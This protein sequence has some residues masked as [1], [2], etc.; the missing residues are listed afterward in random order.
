MLT[1]AIVLAVLAL[2]KS[3]LDYLCTPAG[4]VTATNIQARIAVVQGRID[5][6]FEKLDK[7]GQK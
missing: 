2:L 3:E 6:W 5:I 7:L 4:Q 1:E